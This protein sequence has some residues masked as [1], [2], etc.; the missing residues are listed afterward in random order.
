MLL[1]LSADTL[2]K[3]AADTLRR[4]ILSRDLR[5]GAELPSERDLSES[6]SVS[7]NIVREAL[8]MLMVECMIIKKPGCG[9][10]VSAFDRRMAMA[11][12]RTNIAAIGYSLSELA[13][14][15]YAIELGAASLMAKHITANK[16]QHHLGGVREDIEFHEVLLHS[17]HNLVIVDFLPMLI[18]YFRLMVLTSPLVCRTMPCVSSPNILPLLRPCVSAMP[19]WC[20][21]HSLRIFRLCDWREI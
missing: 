14:A 10:F 21:R 1:P 9:I 6:L 15:R 4:Y 13:E 8:T 2:A 19:P 3:Q 7:R 5:E 12:V 18:E 20:V 16:I 17:T 11:R